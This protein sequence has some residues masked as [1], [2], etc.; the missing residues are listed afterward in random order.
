MLNQIHQL[1]MGQ[2]MLPSRRRA[3]LRLT[4]RAVKSM[5]VHAVKS[6]AWALRAVKCKKRSRVSVEGNACSPPG[7]LFRGNGCATPGVC[8]GGMDAYPGCLF[9]GN[10]GCATPG[11]DAYPGFLFRG[12]WMCIPWIRFHPTITPDKQGRAVQ[13]QGPS[14]DM[15]T[16]H[17]K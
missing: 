7:C 1:K 15:L 3:A 12:G 6:M 16:R 11:M 13:R 8:L 4:R 2:L 10:D 14:E 9:R 17:C 5:A